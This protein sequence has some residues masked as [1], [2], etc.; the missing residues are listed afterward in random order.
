MWLPAIVLS[1]SLQ[2]ALPPCELPEL[3]GAGDAATSDHQ[4]K[5]LADGN[6]GIAMADPMADNGER[7][8]G[9][10][11]GGAPE[12]PHGSGG[13]WAWSEASGWLLVPQGFAISRAAVGVD[14]S[15]VIEMRDPKAPDSRR[16]RAS[17]SGSCVGCAYSS[18]APYFES[19]REA[20]H[21]NEFEFCQGLALPIVRDASSDNRLRFHY[22]NARGV[23]HDAVVL[24]G[25]EEVGFEEL[26]VTGLSPELRDTLLDAFTVE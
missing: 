2:S 10:P 22:D 4:I 8:P 21:E 3:T 17:S 15:W 26:V 20:A 11:E 14:G 25:A 24:I 5:V 7:L 18:G 1:L 12:R 23:R 9:V 16:V 19:Y 6:F 13:V